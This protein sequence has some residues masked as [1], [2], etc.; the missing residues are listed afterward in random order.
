MNA[1]RFAPQEIDVGVRELDSDEADRLAAHLAP[2]VA[3]L[4]R[5]AVCAAI[6]KPAR[7]MIDGIPSGYKRASLLSA[8]RFLGFGENVEKLLATSPP[9]IKAARKPHTATPGARTITHEQARRVVA[10][11]DA[12]DYELPKYTITR[13]EDIR[14]GQPVEFRAKA[15]GD[16]EAAIGVERLAAI[17]GKVDV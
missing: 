11:L 17:L 10:I 3:R 12:A 5:T 6:G 4:G 7:K 9:K 1:P 13:L 16:I 2:H 15:I 14:R 8:S